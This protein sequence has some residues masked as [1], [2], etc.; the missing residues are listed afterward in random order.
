M[1]VSPSLNQNLKVTRASTCKLSV[2]IER[3]SKDSMDL[4]GYITTVQCVVLGRTDLCMGVTGSGIGQN[5]GLIVTGT[6]LGF[7]VSGI[8]LDLGWCGLQSL[9]LVQGCPVVLREGHYPC[10]V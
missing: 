8:G 7:A 5:V 3:I 1:V 2:A 6:G 10:R 4:N 9:I